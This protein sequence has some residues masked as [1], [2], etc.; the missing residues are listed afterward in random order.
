MQRKSV[1]FTFL[2]FSLLRAYS[3]DTIQQNNPEEEFARMRML[4]SEGDYDDAKQIGYS[5]L[6]DN[7]EYFDVALFLARIHGWESSFDSAFILID[8]V[9]A[10]TPDLYEAYET[11]ADLAYWENNLQK[12]DSCA[13]GAAELKPDSGAV[14]ERYRLALQQ[15][16]PR[17]KK[18]EIFAYYSYDHF[19]VPY[20]RNWHMLTAGGELPIK[21]GTLIPFLNGGYFAGD[22]PS[23][24]DIQINVDAYLT[25][26]KKNYAMLGYGFSPHG[27]ANFFPGHRGAA[28]VWQ[29]LPRG[30]ALSGGIRYFY[31]DRH[32]WF[33]TLSGEKYSGN[34]WF[35]FRTYL[36]FKDYGISG[37]YYL[38]ARRYFATE[39]DHL[40]L[41]LGYGTAP[42]EPILVVSDLDRLNALSGRLAFSKKISPRVRLNTMVGYA[43]EEYANQQ[44]RNRIDA[45][46]GAYFLIIR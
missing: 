44:Y 10:G 43:W 40:T 28:E 2:V 34:Y 12:L 39:F 33:L 22:L 18:P 16:L 30:F 29:I 36:F 32:F 41:T 27:V 37:S 17:P 14:F 25:L 23:K 7:G 15:T 5:L 1:V 6:N 19:S 20:Q 35:N 3:Q 24:T 9:L 26:G 13:R 8:W 42:D 11:C 31:W 21:Q 38:S 45:R 46:V 4:A